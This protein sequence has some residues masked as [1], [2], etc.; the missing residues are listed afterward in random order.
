M[1]SKMDIDGLKNLE[2]L[3]DKNSKGTT[4]EKKGNEE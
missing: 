3:D 1:G 4:P 2:K